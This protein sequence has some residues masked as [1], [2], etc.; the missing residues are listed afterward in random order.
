MPSDWT[1]TFQSVTID[2]NLGATFS[3]NGYDDAPT[4]QSN[5]YLFFGKVE[6]TFQAAPGAGIVSSFILIS[7]DLDELD[8]EVIG[9]ETTRV[10]SNYFG[11]GNTT[12][13]DRGGFHNVNSPQTT[14]HVYTLDWNSDK[15]TWAIDGTVVRTLNYGDAV[16][17]QNYPQTPMQIRLGNWVAGRPGNAQ[18]T[19]DWAGGIADL[20]KAPF[21]FYVKTCSVT[22]Y[23]PS[24]SYTY[25]DESGSFQSINT[26]SGSSETSS[27]ASANIS[28]IN[29]S[30]VQ[31]NKPVSDSASSTTPTA[32][33]SST[34]TSKTDSPP[35]SSTVTS[36]TQS[37]TGTNSNTMLTASAL[38]DSMLVPTPNPVSFSNPVSTALSAVTPAVVDTS[39]AR[40]TVT[41]AESVALYPSVPSTSIVLSATSATPC[42]SSIL[43]TSPIDLVSS[44]TSDLGAPSSS[45]NSGSGAVS[46]SSTSSGLVSSSTVTLSVGGGNSTVTGYKPTTPVTS[47]TSAT[48][49]GPAQVTTNAA[50]GSYAKSGAWGLGLVMGLALLL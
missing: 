40:S 20:S 50:V 30:S 46:D 14:E 45:A 35:P 2:P 8:V 43:S 42:T 34:V 3:V 15:T 4:M 49:S 23:N 32:A 47:F 21:N 16:G 13:Y 38:F 29:T 19:V 31:P 36:S 48:S 25:S 17:G 11:K 9:S 7:D 10:Q 27:I 1:M 18:G 5:W 22:N 6:C 28:A 12:T 39:T 41:P 24:S 26:G 37:V 33:P 44:L